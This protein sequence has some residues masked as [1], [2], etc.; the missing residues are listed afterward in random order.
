[1][2]VNTKNITLMPKERNIIVCGEWLTDVHMDHFQQL[3][4]SCSDYRSVEA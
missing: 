2:S 1:M 3:L 4:A